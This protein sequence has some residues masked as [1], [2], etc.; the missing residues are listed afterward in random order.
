MPA[1]SNSGLERFPTSHYHSATY[2]WPV[3]VARKKLYF[4]AFLVPQHLHNRTITP[5]RLL[6]FA[7]IRRLFTASPQQANSA[8]PPTK[9]VRLPRGR[10][11]APV[12]SRFAWSNCA[13]R[14]TA[15][16]QQGF[17]HSRD[18]CSPGHFSR[19]ALFMSQLGR[20]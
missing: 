9:K 11:L 7:T 2:H 3:I 8:S 4:V 14:R 13:G 20:N 18:G 10:N 12:S 5:S 19:A 16:C 15:A 6:V 1:L 17:Q